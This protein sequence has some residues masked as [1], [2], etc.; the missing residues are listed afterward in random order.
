MNNST[1][2]KPEII[3]QFNHAGEVWVYTSSYFRS[4]KPIIVNQGKW[5][6]SQSRWIYSG[7]FVVTT[8]WMPFYVPNVLGF[9]TIVVM[10]MG[11]L[12]VWTSI[13][14]ISVDPEQKNWSTY[15]L[16]MGRKVQLKMHPLGRVDALEWINGQLCMRLQNGESVILWA[17]ELALRPDDQKVQALAKRLGTSLKL[18]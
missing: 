7:L 5:L 2:E 11:L 16:L 10:G 8:W 18:S 3:Q 15:T 12:V 13:R 1:T 4:M 9:L 17:G 14:V 6:S